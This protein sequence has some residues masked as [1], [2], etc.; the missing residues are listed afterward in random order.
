V[1]LGPDLMRS[2]FSL[3][4]SWPVQPLVI[5]SFSPDFCV[6]GR[7]GLL[8]ASILILI[9]T[10]PPHDLVSTC[11]ETLEYVLFYKHQE[12]YRR[13]KHHS[14]MPTTHLHTPL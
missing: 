10:S 5:M 4:L 2:Q 9:M 1:I 7:T 6:G 12:Y 11:A 14:S 13:G 8:V 3:F